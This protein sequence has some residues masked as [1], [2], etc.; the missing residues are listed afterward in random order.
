MISIARDLHDFLFKCILIISV[1][2][3]LVKEPLELIRLF[4]R[5]ELRIGK[6]IWQGIVEAVI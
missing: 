4:C 6:T 5:V 2:E 3:P 1:I